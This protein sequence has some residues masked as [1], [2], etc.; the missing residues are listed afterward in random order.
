MNYHILRLKV[1]K[2]LNKINKLHLEVGIGKNGPRI[3]GVK[4]M[5]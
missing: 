4:L 3:L 5:G 1:E 2:K